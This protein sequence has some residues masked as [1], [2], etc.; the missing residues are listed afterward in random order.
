L[1]KLLNVAINYI[2][3]LP[4]AGNRA[5]EPL[6]YNN[7]QQ[8]TTE[9]ND[10]TNK[11]ATCE[12]VNIFESSI[13]ERLSGLNAEIMYYLFIAFTRPPCPVWAIPLDLVP[14]PN[15]YVIAQGISP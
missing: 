8:T 15:S 12:K 11:A 6:A 10:K 13:A 3:L 1:S 7:P 4:P 14:S 9:V 2:S 5:R